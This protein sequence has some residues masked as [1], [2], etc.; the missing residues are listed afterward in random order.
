MI[1]GYFEQDKLNRNHDERL[2]EEG[3]IELSSWVVKH[4]VSTISIFFPEFPDKN[5]P[6]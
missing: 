1:E 5:S 4:S 3:D 2:N 6:Q